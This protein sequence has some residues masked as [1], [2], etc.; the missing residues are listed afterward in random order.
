[1]SQLSLF[2]ED[3]LPVQG[4]TEIYR[5]L[6]ANA[7]KNL[8]KGAH[9][10]IRQ[11]KAPISTSGSYTKTD[12]VTW[13]GGIGGNKRETTILFEYPVSTEVEREQTFSGPSA[14]KL[15]KTL[16]DSVGIEVQRD[17][18]IT[19]F[20][21]YGIKDDKTLKADYDL[22]EPLLKEE[23]K[24]YSTRYVICI[25][26]NIFKKLTNIESDVDEF[27]GNYVWSEEYNV[28]VSWI[29]PAS[30]ITASPEDETSWVVDLR[31]LFHKHNP[32][33]KTSWEKQDKLPTHRPNNIKELRSLVDKELS[34]S[35]PLT[36][37]AIDTE[38]VPL[39]DWREACCFKI[40]ISSAEYNID[41]HLYEPKQGYDPIY[42]KATTGIHQNTPDKYYT[43]KPAKIFFETRA[44]FEL[45]QK[46]HPIR[47]QPIHAYVGEY[48]WCFN[49]GQEE[50]AKELTRLLCRTG[51]SL[52]GQ[53]A[54]SDYKLILKLGT[55][56]IPYIKLDT[57]TLAKML[58]ESQR[59]GLETLSRRY[60]GA[61]SH[62]LE[63]SR[64]LV[65]NQ[66]SGTKLPYIFVPRNIID[67][68]ATTDSRRTYDLE[69]PMMAQLI[70]LHTDAISLGEP[71]PLNAYF[72][73]KMPEFFCLLDME[74]VGQPLN[75][76]ILKKCQEWYEEK[77]KK[78]LLEC[79]TEAKSLTE[80]PSFNPDSN[81]DIGYLLFTVLK[82]K[83]LYSTDKPPIPW[84]EIETLPPQE[85]A[86]KKPAVDQETLEMLSPE[87][88]LCKKLNICRILGTIEKNYLRKGAR[89]CNKEVDFPINTEE[90]FTLESDS[91]TEQPK[92][93][94]RIQSERYLAT[95]LK[96]E[97]FW[98]EIIKDRKSRAI[99]Q[100]VNNSG[101]VHT[102]YSELLETDRLASM[103]NVSAVTK[104]E[105]DAVEE[106]T[107][108]R[109]PYSIREQ[110]E[111]HNQTVNIVEGKGM[112]IIV[113]ERNKFDRE[114]MFIE[115]DWNT[116]EVWYLAVISNDP[117]G[118]AIMGDKTR[119]IHASVARNMFPYIPQD[120][121]DTD[122]KKKYKRERDD[123]K[124][125]V[126]GIP[127]G[128]GA[129]A[130]VRKLNMEAVK[131]GDKPRY[132]DADGQ[133]F[134]KSYQETLPRGWA[135]LQEQK[136]RVINPGYLV[137]PWGFRRRFPK[138]F[139]SKMQLSAFQREALNWQIQHGIA[140]T[141]MEATKAWLRTKHKNP[142]MPM[143]LT[144]ILHDATKFFVHGSMYD[145][146]MEI[147]HY[148]MDEGLELPFPVGAKLRHSVDISAGWCGTHITKEELS[149][150]AIT[151][152]EIK[153]LVPT[154]ESSYLLHST[155]TE[156]QIC[157][158]SI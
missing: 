82:L 137:S 150:R 34:R 120:M 107:G 69:E 135:Y 47:K 6:Q 104:G 145:E 119:D 144:D 102:S 98:E 136:E 140:C 66:A 61:P 5:D 4:L 50:L 78:L 128:R 16:K 62:K 105:L 56:L 132:N 60:L 153:K 18:R 89:W 88:P 154:A 80:L 72:T 42:L 85:R 1:M 75:V 130:L 94:K 64:W 127:Y 106:M 147:I 96:P 86:A 37:F 39:R 43:G 49:G 155:L 23:I 21:K 63:I 118:V 108:E 129:A 10:S 29:W 113:F 112:D 103:P 71:S 8:I 109:P 59:K 152:E 45:Y 24:T 53:N 90:Q 79:V 114:W 95:S 17:C 27:I 28:F 15:E 2:D 115:S 146:A 151:W 35:K 36:K 121:S 123:A 97:E 7:T 14:H 48:V 142:K 52:W 149:Q 143:F 139:A 26:S 30:A 124:P 87:H 126:F 40:T 46:L 138:N 84:E 55:N 54:R 25:G 33:C 70:Q 68:Y 44:E 125:F 122:I 83:P 148:T 58:D 81:D 141:K 67:P 117:N 3:T 134:I 32:I 11:S 57:I 65:T 31:C 156:N 9:T 22:C 116:G 158:R 20:I 133:V 77:R 41:L 157:P 12:D 51:N 74:I 100:V 92:E 131:R 91:N 76:A 13:L 111:P 101:Y 38:F 93:R 19:Y 110:F 99:S 73:A